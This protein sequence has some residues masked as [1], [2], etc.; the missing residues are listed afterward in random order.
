MKLGL[1]LFFSHWLAVVLVSGSIGTFFYLNAADSLSASLQ[2]RLRNSAAFVAEALKGADLHDIQEAGD[3]DKESY[4]HNLSLLRRLKQTNP[5]IAYLYI[6]RKENG[7][8]IFVIDTDESPKQAKP[9]RNYNIEIPSMQEGFTRPSVD[10]NL[11]SDEWGVFMSGYAP[12]DAPG[13]PYLVGLDMRADE[14]RQKF[15]SLQLSGLISLGASLALA[16]L[17][18]RV[19]AQRLVRHIGAFVRQC[20]TIASGSFQARLELKTGDELDQLV[21]AFNTM[22]VNLSRTQDSLQQANANLELRVIQRTQELTAS[23]E[24]LKQALD[25]VKKLRR[26]LP[27][28]AWCKKMRNDNGYWTELERYVEKEAGVKFSH[29]ICP[30]CAHKLL[31]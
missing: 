16:L 30:D 5:D 20:E 14:V 9:G 2:L 31:Q 12:V 11:L 24:E 15:K 6:M 17:F 21:T 19:L 27:L 28:C 8:T 1:K 23:N 18:S 3:I 10:P 4:K 7:K 29:G 22:A 13:G 25:N 26:L